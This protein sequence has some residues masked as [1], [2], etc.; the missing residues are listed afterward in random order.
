MNSVLFFLSFLFFFLLS[1]ILVFSPLSP[2]RHTAR[3]VLNEYWCVGGV[4]T[5]LQHSEFR[6]RVA[7]CA[8]RWC[9]TRRRRGAEH[10]PSATKRYNTRACGV[11]SYLY[12]PVKISVFFCF[13]LLLLYL[14]FLPSYCCYPWNCCV[15]QRT[16]SPKSPEDGRF[17][18]E[19]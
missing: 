2:R 16:I 17:S 3:W 18:M 11:P 5:T 7:A 4:F 19:V 14:L 10:V 12:L 15:S 6:F 1:N 9:V 8:V 13:F